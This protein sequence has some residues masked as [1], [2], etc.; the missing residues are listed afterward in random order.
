MVTWRTT[1]QEAI[2]FFSKRRG[3]SAPCV[4]CED[5]FFLIAKER[6]YSLPC[7]LIEALA[8]L[9]GKSEKP[10]KMGVQIAHFFCPQKTRDNRHYPLFVLYLRHPSTLREQRGNV[11]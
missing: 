8:V 11:G 10:K 7:A 6:G 9:S 5:G 3:G 2:P 1:E 4:T